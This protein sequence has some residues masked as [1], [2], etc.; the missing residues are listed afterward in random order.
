MTKLSVNINKIATLRNARGGDVP[1]VT[2]VA[3]DA[4]KF[5]AQGI[6]IHPRPDERH[7]TR[8]DVY[9]L[10][11]LVTTEFNIEGNPHRPFIDMVLEVK[12]EQVTLVPDADD[13]ITSN[14]GWDCKMHLDFLKN[15][16]AEFKAEGIR[17]SIF[18]DPN[19][20]MVKYATE[21]GTDRIELYTEAY[22]KG[23]VKNR[24]QAILP[25]IKTAEE[26]INNGLGINAGHD[27]SLENLKYFSDEIPNLLEV[28]IGHALISE[29]LYLGLENTIQSYLKRLAKW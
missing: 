14:A 26:A 25:Y 13:A 10:K 19:P 11:P 12:P 6:T 22:A 2:Q 7:I 5:G 4:Q 27:L 16:I 3:V 29:A 1:S 17:T 8:K 20:E 21:T 24:E 18:L 15:V 23:Y 9:D 28:S